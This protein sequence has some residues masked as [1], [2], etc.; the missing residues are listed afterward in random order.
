M[1]CLCSLAVLRQAYCCSLLLAYAAQILR[2][3]FQPQITYCDQV[4]DC[5]ATAWA[6]VA[7]QGTEALDDVMVR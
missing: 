5:T 7:R 3:S 1:R 2:P 6:H 4:R